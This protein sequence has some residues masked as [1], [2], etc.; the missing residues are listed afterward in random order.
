MNKKIYIATHNS[1]KFIEIQSILHPLKCE[2]IDNSFSAPE[3]TGYSFIE[4][5]LIKARY[6]CEQTQAPCIADDSGLVVPSL[7]GAPG[8]YSARYAGI[9]Q[10]DENHR[11][12]LLQTL[13]SIS[14][15]LAYFYCA[16]VYL[17]HASDPCPVIGLGQWNGLIHTHE[18]GQHGFGY[19]P[20]FFCP[21]LGKTA[22]ELSLTQKNT[23]SH[24]A[25]ALH[26]LSKQLLQTD[27]QTF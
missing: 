11:E 14:D 26:Q 12:K 25:Q 8:I 9:D 24:R 21:K 15:R 17:R 2:Q 3:E 1:H 20:I 13:S 22:A 6:A 5:A 10:P 16:V 18:Q 19:D 7:N 23:L 27:F 4:N